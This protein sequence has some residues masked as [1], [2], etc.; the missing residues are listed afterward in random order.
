MNVE[1]LRMEREGDLEFGKKK[2]WN[3]EKRCIWS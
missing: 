3:L 2:F 1:F